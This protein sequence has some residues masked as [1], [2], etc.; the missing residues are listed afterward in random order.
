MRFKHRICLIVAITPFLFDASK[1]AVAQIAAAMPSNER[2]VYTVRYVSA[3]D[4]LNNVLPVFQNTPGTTLIGSADANSN[5]I[6]LSGPPDTVGEAVKI[7]QMLDRQPKS[8]SIDIWIVDT[9]STGWEATANKE[10]DAALKGSQTKLVELL[11]KVEAQKQAVVLNHL[12]LTSVEG[13]QAMVQLGER[14]PRV[15]GTTRNNVG[16]SM[17]VALEDMGTTAKVTPRV[18]ADRKIVLAIELGKSF[19]AP[20]ETGVVIAEAADGTPQTRSPS[21]ITI[22]AKTTLDL[23]DGELAS[24]STLA[25]GAKDVGGDIRVLVSAQ[26]VPPQPEANGKKP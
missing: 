12:Q 20:E 23:G 5:S 26:I 8:V 13:V 18:S 15:T 14:K 6:L 19:S 22:Q 4:L 2:L 25:S 7:L 3:A 9:R 11:Q 17:S 1:S 24:L 10:I 16:R 21:A